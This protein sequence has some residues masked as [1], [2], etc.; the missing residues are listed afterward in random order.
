MWHVIRDLLFSSALSVRGKP[1]GLLFSSDG[2]VGG[3]VPE[4]ERSKNA[5]G[6]SR[7]L[8]RLKLNTILPVL[9]MEVFCTLP[10]HGRI[11]LA[12]FLGV[13]LFLKLKEIKINSLQLRVDCRCLCYRDLHI[14]SVVE[15]RDKSLSSRLCRK[16]KGRIAYL[17]PL[18]PSFPQP[19]CREL[20][21]FWFFSCQP[22]WC[23]PPRS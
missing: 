4:T 12:H 5:Q 8:G 9:P 22:Y 19:Q 13:G 2:W 16:Q 1:A 6:K 10:S 15:T 23:A 7:E 3:G 14:F 11:S 21:A 17:S 20:A 18:F